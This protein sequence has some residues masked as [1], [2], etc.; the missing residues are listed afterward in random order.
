MSGLFSCLRA[1]RSGRWTAD[2]KQEAFSA[3]GKT[4]SSGA[5]HLH[6]AIKLLDDALPATIDKLDGGAFAPNMV[7]VAPWLGAVVAAY[8]MLVAGGW[9]L[10]QTTGPASKSEGAYRTSAVTRS[11]I[12][13]P[14]S[15]T[16]R[17]GNPES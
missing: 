8:L 1:L 15:Q 6:D 13:D 5:S 14:L 16:A 11:P 12:S 17:S 4:L 9:C 10:K 2:E 7:A 3:G